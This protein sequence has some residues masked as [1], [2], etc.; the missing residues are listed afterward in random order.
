[1][2]MNNM[3]LNEWWIKFQN[4]AKQVN[5]APEVT[6]VVANSMMKEI[7]AY[8]YNDLTDEQKLF[9]GWDGPDLVINCVYNGQHCNITGDWWAGWKK[10][11]SLNFFSVYLKKSKHGK[12]N[13]VKFDRS[14]MMTSQLNRNC[15]RYPPIFSAKKPDRLPDGGIPHPTLVKITISWVFPWNWPE[16]IMDCVC[17]GQL[18]NFYR[19]SH[20][21]ISSMTKV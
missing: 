1:M 20:T 16:L 15:E 18:C 17:N 12:K 10:P 7:A 21:I 8:F 9:V 19:T 2:T 5:A 14:T 6:K 13:K 11:I 4:S 3:N